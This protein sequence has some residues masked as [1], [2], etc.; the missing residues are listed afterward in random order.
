[1]EDET[2]DL[3]LLQIILT[4]IAAVLF[5]DEIW[6]V[7]PELGI[8]SPGWILGDWSWLHIEPFHHWMWAPVLIVFAWIILPI[9]KTWEGQR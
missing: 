1:M 3:L 7:L 9:Y 6:M 5:L 4:I 2:R 8:G